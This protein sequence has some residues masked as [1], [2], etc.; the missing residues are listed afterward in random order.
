[1]KN[2]KTFPIFVS[3]SYVVGIIMGL[4]LFFVSTWA[5]LESSFYG[6][7]RLA[8][9]GLRGFS[10]PVIMTP[11]DTS[12]ISLTVSNPTDQLLRPSVKTMISTP[13]MAD[14]YLNQIELAPG[15]TKQLKWTVGPGNIDMG[16]FIF[17]KALIFSTYPLPS[18]EDTCGI[19]IVNLPG[20][21]KVIFPLFV[22]V[23]LLGMGWGVYGM[24][25]LGNVNEWM[26]RNLRAVVFLTLTIVL[27]I[28]LSFWGGWIL[29]IFL[30]VVAF[31]MLVI[32]M[33]SFIL[34]ERRAPTFNKQ[35]Y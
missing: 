29:S 19:F 12:T 1:M 18:L 33:G 32:L 9:A 7:P 3:L 14:E 28:G 26:S 11:N 17:A 25:K 31:L 16:Q 6:F 30:M 34:N 22:L 21:G 10:C 15:E 4:F 5:D 8:N 27:G 13:L 24:K 20:S 2:T 23:S 35:I